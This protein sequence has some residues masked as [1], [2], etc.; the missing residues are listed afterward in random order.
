VSGLDVAGFGQKI[1]A[2]WAEH[3][4][5][6]LLGG[7][8]AAVAYGLHAR[9][10]AA[11]PSSG[12]DAPLTDPGTTGVGAGIAGYTGATG[13]AYDSTA[14][15][16]YNALQPQLATTQG[17]LATVLSAA[18]S[19]TSAAKSAT[20]AAHKATKA[21]NAAAKKSK[22]KPKKPHKKPTRKS[23]QHHPQSRGRAIAPPAPRR[24][25]SVRPANRAK[26]IPSTR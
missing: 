6:I 8:G 15:D 4:K 21:A 17:L 18:K 12:T 7:A 14:N 26:T 5:L 9:T 1:S 23:R 3:K 13:A 2:M 20:T 16:V 25:P 10:Q 11:A 24:V 19:A 22:K